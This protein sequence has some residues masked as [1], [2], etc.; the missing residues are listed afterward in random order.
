[1]IS[2]YAGSSAARCSGWVT[3]LN[4]RRSAAPAALAVALS[5]AQ[6]G[7]AGLRLPPAPARLPVRRLGAAKLALQEVDLAPPVGRLAGDP[8]V[9]DALGVAP[10]LGGPPA[11]ASDQLP[12]RVMVSARCT[13]QRPMYATMSDWR[14]HHCRMGLRPLP[15]TAQLEHALTER[16]RV[17]ED[18]AGD[19]RRQLL[20]G[21]R[22]H[23]LV[24][25][26]EAL[27][28]AAV[29][30]EGV[31]LLHHGER[32]QI[33]IAEPRADRR[34]PPQR[35]RTRPRGHRPPRGRARPA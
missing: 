6:Q 5:Q 32:D 17:A 19:D 28:D 27:G 15:G 18:G 8:L 4:A 22:H 24:H 2:T 10:R 9:Q 21:D 25:Q 34:R 35:P 26:P 12:A 13:R 29:P 14:S 23:R 20:R 3:S 33:S 1:M 16:D 31:A 30:D 11:I 7:K